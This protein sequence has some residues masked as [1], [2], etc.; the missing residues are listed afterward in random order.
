MQDILC[1]EELAA[2]AVPAAVLQE[3]D[4]WRLR[5]N[6]GVTRRANSVLAMRA[7]WLPLAEKIAV[8]EDFYWRRDIP[9]RFQL[10]PTSARSFSTV[11]WQHVV[12]R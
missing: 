5:F 8:A 1:I 3:L 12:I 10:N 7:G 2:N 11:P 4:G 6:W 9:C